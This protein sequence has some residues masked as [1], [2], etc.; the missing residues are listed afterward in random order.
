[1]NI[2]DLI[3][4]AQ[5][6]EKAG[7]L[8]Q[9]DVIWKTLL[10]KD[11]QQ[12]DALRAL[13]SRSAAAAATESPNQQKTATSVIKTE[14][15][16]LATRL[17]KKRALNPKEDMAY[18]EQKRVII[19][20]AFKEGRFQDVKIEAEALTQSHPDLFF[21][22][23]ALGAACSELGMAKEAALYIEKSLTLNPSDAEGWNNLSSI[24]CDLGCYS[25]ALDSSKK[26]IN[27]NSHCAP[28]YY[29][30]GNSCIQLKKFEEA[31]V[32]FEKTLKIQKDH[33][34]AN[35]GIGRAFLG[36]KQ[37]DKAEVCFKKTLLINPNCYTSLANLGYIFY[38]KNKYDEALNFI[39]KSMENNENN[40]SEYSSCLW[41]EHLL[42]FSAKNIS[43]KNLLENAKKYE[44]T[45]INSCRDFEQYKKWILYEKKIKIG[46][47]S[48]DFFDHAV[49]H[50]LHFI[51]H[52]SRKNITIK[53]YSNTKIKLYDEKTAI[54]K[55]YFCE[56]DDISTLSDNDAAKKIHHDGICILIDLS[57]HTDGSRL[58]V[59]ARKPAPIQVTWIGWMGTTGLSSIDYIIGDK[60]LTPSE[61]EDDFVEKPW[62]M[63]R[64]HCCFS[65]KASGLDFEVSIQPFKLDNKITFGSLNKLMKLNDHVIDLWCKALLDVPDSQILIC[66]FKFSELPDEIEKTYQRFENRGV[67][68][69]RV[70]IEDW[71]KDRV[72]YIS[73]YNKIDIALNPFPYG[74][75]TISVEAIWM[76]V[77][78]LTKRGDRYL[79]RITDSVLHNV[80]LEDWIAEDE[81]EYVRK[82]IAFAS[83]PKK[84]GDIRN[85]MRERAL[86][87]P[88][89]N[90]TLFADDFEDAM[91][92][93]WETWLLNNPDK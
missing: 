61:D 49:S 55:S 51:K 75:G 30:A 76:G 47:I 15:K 57:G 87:S 92:E 71:E 52:V 6:H 60:H 62:R 41:E 53:A 56:W 31:I 74:G 7:R 63:K 20:N 33:Y 65:A 91:Q 38:K 24:Q 64:A 45:V 36:K 16:A 88:M 22:W 83:D 29:N 12:P 79:S 4:M 27:L 58:P 86:A 21:G 40:P 59:F 46:F 78:V 25:D 72:E 68:R 69:E 32:F 70:I 73:L 9:A 35:L 2:D 8:P 43:K 50:F 5:A 23:K 77:P 67:S 81:E 44:K 54:L 19:Q 17:P 3:R 26:S 80:G 48:G 90:E 10:K 82:A 11:P 14:P 18:L 93:M 13:A 39:Q 66:A 89:F 37:D 34:K 28:A 42:Y 84:L 1:M 85:T